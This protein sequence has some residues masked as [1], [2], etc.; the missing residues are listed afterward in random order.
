MV[1]GMASAAVL[2]TAALEGTVYTRSLFSY[3]TRHMR[4]EEDEDGEHVLV[5][6]IKSPTGQLLKKIPLETITSV[7][8]VDELHHTFTITST[9]LTVVDGRVGT[10]TVRVNESHA[11][12]ML[13]VNG[14]KALIGEAQ[15]KPALKSLRPDPRKGPMSS[16]L[17]QRGSL[18]D[19]TAI[20]VVEH[21]R[22]TWAP[23]AAGWEPG[24]N[25]W[26]RLPV[27]IILITALTVIFGTHAP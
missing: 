26:W 9:A 21:R 6:R 1:A 27:V 17:A 10:V 2:A 4:V 7:K 15:A 23:D 20:E 12:L 14:L 22:F 13:W 5:L 18:L 19:G 25:L 8:L 3:E 16:Q 24:Q 11:V